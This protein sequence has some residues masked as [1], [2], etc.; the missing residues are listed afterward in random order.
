MEDRQ[1]IESLLKRQESDDLDFKSGQYNLRN[2]HGKSKF[3]KDIVAMAKLLTR[4]PHLAQPSDAVNR[5][6]SLFF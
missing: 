5:Q 4:I 3:I 1:L 2:N 6:L